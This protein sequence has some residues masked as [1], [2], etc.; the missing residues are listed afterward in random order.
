MTGDGINTNPRQ[1][2]ILKLIQEEEIDKQEELV[3]RLN[4]TGF[5]V[6]QHS[7]IGVSEHVCS[8]RTPDRFRRSFSQHSEA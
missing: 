2:M 1:A 7:R 6:T 5:N 8:D 3:R 4:E